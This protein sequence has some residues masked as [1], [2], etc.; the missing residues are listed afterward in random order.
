MSYR[1]LNY[2]F[3]DLDHVPRLL[4]CER[5]SAGTTLDDAGNFASHDINIP[6]LSS[7]GL[8]VEP[9]RSNLLT[10]SEAFD[11]VVWTKS[12]VSVTADAV[13]APDGNTS[14]DILVEDNSTG[15]HQIYRNEIVSSGAVVTCSLWVKSEG[16]SSLTLLVANT[17]HTFGC[18][19]DLSTSGMTPTS[20]GDGA[21]ADYG[22]IPAANGWYRVYITGSISGVTVY[23]LRARLRNVSDSYTGDGASGLYVWGAQFELGYLTSYIA[24]NASSVQR[25]DDAFSTTNL[26][27][28]N[29]AEGTCLCE[30]EAPYT[31]AA[32]AAQRL[33]EFS[34]GTTANRIYLAAENSNIEGHV[35]S[36]GSSTAALSAAYTGGRGSIVRVAFRYTSAGAALCVGGGA[37][38]TD[39][40]VILPLG[41]TDFHLGSDLSKNNQLGGRIRRFACWPYAV[42]DNLLQELA[43]L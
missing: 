2:L 31:D 1:T 12:G 15:L 5:A 11:D 14:A 34:D 43:S 33:F 6:R 23:S 18:A 4:K 16:R 26:K 40:T 24:T 7:Q 38:Q 35:A 30:I 42:S 19:F 21:I 37:V 36:G 25:E 29:S 10:K 17:T 8:L 28:F 22:I 27:W 39:N 41:L 32:S 20:A 13:A 3:T 9:T